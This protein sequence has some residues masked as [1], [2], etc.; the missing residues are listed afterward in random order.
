M[1]RTVQEVECDPSGVRRASV[2]SGTAT[3]FT[4]I[5]AAGDA[6]KASSLFW[7]TPT[8]LCHSAEMDERRSGRFRGCLG[9]A[10]LSTARCPPLASSV[11]LP[12]FP[13]DGTPDALA[14]KQKAA[15]A[16]SPPA[17][18]GRGRP[19]PTFQR[20]PAPRRSRCE[21]PPPRAR[22]SPRG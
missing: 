22:L 3:I 8:R 2:A 17:R 11:N 9:A 14:V 18:N 20:S 1:P 21:K 5:P 16:S 4:F 10:T 13:S 12:G 6:L 15:T 7:P 19:P